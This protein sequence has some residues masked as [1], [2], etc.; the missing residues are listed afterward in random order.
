MHYTHCNTLK[1]YLVADFQGCFSIDV[2]DTKHK[3]NSIFSQP[4][5]LV[6]CFVYFKAQGTE[7]LMLHLLFLKNTVVLL[8]TLLEQVQ[9]KVRLAKP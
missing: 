1:C 6:K 7:A 2:L 3:V 4:Y 9:K 8:L 5:L